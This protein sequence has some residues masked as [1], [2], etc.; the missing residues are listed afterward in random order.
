VAAAAVAGTRR[1][2]G[3]WWRAPASWMWP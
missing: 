2:R 3:P 1:S